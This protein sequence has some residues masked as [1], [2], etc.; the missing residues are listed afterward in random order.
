MNSLEKLLVEFQRRAEDPNLRHQI[1]ISEV[2]DL[3]ARELD[4]A[5]RESR[6]SLTPHLPAYCQRLLHVAL[7]FD[8][9]SEQGWE[10]IGN[11]A[12]ACQRGVV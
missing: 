3:C 6:P 5:I 10:D 9:H 11:A 4:I 12:I 7:R 2:F 1:M 8:P